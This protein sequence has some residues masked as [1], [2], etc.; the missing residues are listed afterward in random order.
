M[1]F[2]ATLKSIVLLAATAALAACGGGGGSDSDSGF[3]PQGLS[4]TSST[5][6]LSLNP[7]SLSTITA[8]LRQASGTPVADGTTITATVNGAGLGNISA[9]NGDNGGTAQGTTVGGV[10]NFYFQ[11]GGNPGSGSITLSAQDPGVQNRTVSRT[12]NV[13]V[14][15][16][17]GTDPRISFQPT[18]T[19]IAVNTNNVPFFLGSPYI[20]EVV[21]NV[22]SASGQPIND[23]GDGDQ[24]IQFSV[25]PVENGAV[26]VL[27]DPETDDVNEMTTPFG[28]IFTGVSAGVSRAFVWSAENAGTIRLHAAFTDPDTGQRV[29]GVYDFNLVSNVPP[30]PGT[31]TVTAPTGPI[32]NTGSGGNGSGT[33][34]IQVTD[35]AGSPV[36]NPVAGGVA[37]NNV[38]LELLPS[39]GNGDATLSATDA[40]G[41]EQ[42]GTSIVV[43]TTNGVANA[44]VLA[45][46]ETGAYI[47]RATSD[48]ADNNVDNGITSPVVGE[49]TFM[50][51]DGRLFSVSLVSPDIEA[52]VANRVWTGIFDDDGAPVPGG[53]DGTYS[54]T[55]SVIATDRQ[56]NPVLPGTP[57]QFGLIDG[58][59]E[60]FPENG[61]GEF[62]KRGG[63][64]NPQEGGTL[65]TAPNG[66]FTTAPGGPNDAVGPGD[67]LLVFG[68][69]VPGNRDLESAR[70]I[71]TVNSATS[72]TV[73]QPFNENDDTGVS[74]DFGNVLPYVIGR[75]TVGTIGATAATNELG[76][77][78]TT[79]NYPVSMLGR[80]VGIWARGAANT[81][82]G[83]KLVS[84]VA[85]AV[86]PGIAPATLVASPSAIPGN[87][88][89]FVTVCLYDAN[90][91]PIQGVFVD[92]GFDLESGTGR[93]DGQAGS[94]QLASAT[95]AS[96]CA[97]AEVSTV[98]ITGDGENQVLFS[99]PGIE[100][101]AAV[102]INVSGDLILQA[103][104][105]AI[106][107][108]GTYTIN[109][110]LLDG[111]GNGVPGAAISGT[112][113]GS[114]DTAIVNIS[115]Q[116]NPTNA[117]GRT[118]ATIV[119][120]NMDQ[121]DGG[122][123]WTCTFAIA[124]GE[125]SADVI[126]KGRDS[127]QDGIVPSP[128]PAADQCEDETDPPVNHVI[129]VNLTAAAG[130]AGGTVL[131]APAGI[132]CP[133]TPG[134]TVICS[135]PFSEEVPVTLAITPIDP[136]PGTPERPR[137]TVSGDCN[138]TNPPNFPGPA[139][140]ATLPPRT[141]VQECNITL[142]GG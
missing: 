109:L 57:I 122:A 90:S 41:Q 102:E 94:G 69:L 19:D 80:R 76:V 78:T 68:D 63:N 35:G 86:Y 22:R 28:S 66:G 67:T 111:G 7:R 4:L 13:T 2:A 17:P 126:I 34:S 104:P 103:T 105:T 6:S 33:I 29:E 47:I 24:A 49:R 20:S 108:N 121:P 31:V 58:P 137:P 119:A 11:S 83:Q 71:A 73:V 3:T 64:G 116:P 43:R 77:A 30:L 85:L 112:C 138:L 92:F 125:P 99:V 91:S 72:L 95:G 87:T 52:I 93:V 36:P 70:T 130:S 100:E 88:T 55:V 124:G 42:R 107:G 21:V 59:L 131:S 46:A 45:G 113:E 26:S 53:L 39:A 23:D 37:F 133:V 15:N 62:V 134:D 81:T 141:T 65:F 54:L 142:N 16:G 140:T 135:F 79:M 129:T 84:D 9:G 123:E 48:R 117:E 128:P 61:P 27:D 132:N 8:T 89:T 50:I 60:G 118:T 120:S 10:V 18:K 114:G 25:T 5:S 38:R 96:G 139:F 75:A 136:T 74:V 51:S 12:V 82:D 115:Q 98:G 56:G 44:L 1:K 14:G 97:L 40:S 127:C 32:Y 106:L 101:P 110:R